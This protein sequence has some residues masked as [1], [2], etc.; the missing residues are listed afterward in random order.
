MNT[1]DLA[2]WTACLAD[3]EIAQPFPQ[4]HRAL[5]FI[6]A[7]E[8]A[9]SSL[10]RFRGA[11]VAAGWLRG[12][13]P[14]WRLGRPEEHAL[15]VMLERE[16]GFRDGARGRATLQFRPGIR[17]G[18]PEPSEGLQELGTLDLAGPAAEQRR[19]FGDLDPV[20][21]SEMLYEIAALIGRR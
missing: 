7:D 9:A 4:I 12:P 19:V 1:G 3:F 8:T 6:D 11:Q 5:H 14:G 13:V 16:V 21:A 18:T 17:V 20:T 2:D 15:I 10:A